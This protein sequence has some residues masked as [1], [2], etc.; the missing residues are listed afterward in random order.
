[1]SVGSKMSG[2]RPS[3]MSSKGAPEEAN[4]EAA[5]SSSSSKALVASTGSRLVG[6]DMGDIQADIVQQ[7]D[8]EDARFVLLHIF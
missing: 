8:T 1:M 6:K 3:P 2:R 4:P 7:F 5:N